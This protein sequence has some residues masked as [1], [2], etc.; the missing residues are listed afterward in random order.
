MKRKTKTEDS[1][2]ND[3][4]ITY[5]DL[6]TLLLAFFVLLF[7]FSE[8]DAAKWQEIVESFAGESILTDMGSET[9][10]LEDQSSLIDDGGE[11]WDQEPP[12]EEPEDVGVEEPE[13]PEIEPE[14]PDEPVVEPEKPVIQPAEGNEGPGEAELEMVSARF[15]ELY[16]FLQDVNATDE[17]NLEIIRSKTEIRLRLSDNLL[18]ASGDA[19]LSENARQTLV[20]IVDIVQGYDDVLDKITMEGN[21][22]NLPISTAQFRD[23]FE[24]SLERSLSVLYFFKYNGGFEPKK[25]VPMGYGEYNPVASNDTPEGRAKNRRTDIVLIKRLEE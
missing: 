9:S 11:P 23:N 22:D 5:S 10:I 3:W 13:E 7:S 12:E 20:E 14:K 24:L 17:M 19:R 2:E 16:G 6:V 25:L 15:E 21:T 1:G 4:I 8:I 18:F